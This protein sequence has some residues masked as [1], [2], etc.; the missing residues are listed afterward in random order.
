MRKSETTLLL[1]KIEVAET[2]INEAVFLFFD[3]ASPVITEVLT[4]AALD[5]L[6]PLA[7]REKIKSWL[8]DNAQ[9]PSDQKK[10]WADVMKKP[11][12]FFKH[13][14][15]DSDLKLSY[16][17]ASVECRLLDA[18]HLL[19]K[20][21]QLDLHKQRDRSSSALLF[22]NWFQHKHPELLLEPLKNAET[23][24]PD[25]LTEWKKLACCFRITPYAEG[26]KGLSQ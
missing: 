8:F 4:G 9:V 10:A 7:K 1:N 13:A 2:L 22:A 5:I 14:D 20:L 23:L 17:D 19:T 11:Y 25:D 16:N 6:R 15:R 12:N 18:C 21:N 26:Y 3:N 24:N